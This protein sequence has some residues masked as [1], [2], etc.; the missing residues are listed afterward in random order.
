QDKHMKY[1]LDVEKQLESDMNRCKWFSIQCDES[2]D[3]SDKAQLAVIV[4][5]VFDDFSTKV[6]QHVVLGQSKCITYSEW[7]SVHS[8]LE[9]AVPPQK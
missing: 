3:F 8:Q 6:G 5:M 1:L 9:E 4:R 2:V 7:Q